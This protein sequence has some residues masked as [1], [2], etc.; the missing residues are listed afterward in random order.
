MFGNSEGFSVG[1]LFFTLNPIV[2]PSVLLVI[3]YTIRKFP[4]T[5]RAVYA[6]LQQ[7]DEV[8][9][10]SAINL[11]ASKSRVLWEIIIP[12]IIMNI[13]GGALVSLV[14]NMS[15]VSTTLILVSDTSNG[16]ITWKMAQETGK[17]AELAAMGVF[18]MV[19]QVISLLVT[20]VLLKN[21]ADAISGI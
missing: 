10:E 8:L 17:I 12:L 16:T 6:G 3:S 9:E 1:D 19:L 5:V 18:L 14:Y 20:N 7:T 4:F 2:A 13:I 21:R 11:G 15:E